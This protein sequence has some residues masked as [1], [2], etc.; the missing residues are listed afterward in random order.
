MTPDELKEYYANLL[1]IQYFNRANARAMVKAFSGEV[2]ADNVIPAVR[3]AFDLDTAVGV[4]LDVIGQYRGVSRYVFNFD[5]SKDYFDWPDYSTSDP[6]TFFG[7]AEY[8]ASDATINWFFLRYQDASAVSYTMNDQE[9]R[10]VIRF[11]A[12]TDSSFLS[13]KDIDD[14]LFAIFGTQVTL[15]DNL[16]MTI[17]YNDP[18]TDPNIN[19]FTL[20]D[21]S[22]SLPK[23]AG[24]AVSVTNV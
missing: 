14:I 22:G 7:F 23:P 24:V 13:V 15:I 6:S 3:D 21:E 5:L 20:L 4:Q 1:I 11:R 8:S 10:E 18:L 12:T 17:T 9:Y 19:L 2:I 16:D